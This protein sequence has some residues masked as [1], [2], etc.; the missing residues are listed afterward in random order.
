M[1][2]EVWPQ[3]PELVVNLYTMHVDR[4]SVPSLTAW[5]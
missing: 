5:V 2:I 3:T 1:D 4:L